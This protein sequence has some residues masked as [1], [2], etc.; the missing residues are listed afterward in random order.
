MEANDFHKITDLF[1]RKIFQRIDHKILVYLVFVAI[2][3]VFWFLNELS[4]NYTTTINYPVRFTNLPKNKILVSDLPK[5]LTL[6]VNGYGYTLLR[7]KLSPA[8]FPVVI[9]MEQYSK[10]ISNPNV[11]SY[12]LQTRQIKETIDK[13]MANDIDVLDIMPDTVVF[14][15][16]NII[17]RKIP[18]KP[19]VK[20]NFE[21]ECMLNGD[22]TFSPDSVTV[23]GPNN[24]IDT[25]SAVY[26]HYQE[27]NNLSKPLHRNIT[28]SEIENIEMDRKKAVMFLPVAKF[29]QANFEVPIQA[30][31]TPDTLDL[32]TFPRLAKVTCLVALNDFDKIQ[33][34]DFVIN[35]NYLDI[36]NLLGNRLTLNLAIAPSNAKLI[37]YSPESVE[38][39]L[40]K[41][42]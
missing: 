24:I 33:A 40:D 5:N 15:F 34:K 35:V 42:P 4:N 22:I 36:E 16:A 17:S 37:Q 2:S 8:S 23:N 38:F 7:Y 19:R 1:N 27:F 29:T 12:R 30:I 9:N 20:L 26:T 41:K 18:I 11:K 31:N 14:Q 39:I 28:L 3:T 25:L 6:N 21:E 13:Q 32:K 10:T